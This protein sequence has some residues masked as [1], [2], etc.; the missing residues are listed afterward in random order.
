MGGTRHRRQRPSSI[1]SRR[2]LWIRPS[3]SSAVSQLLRRVH[4]THASA[5]STQTMKMVALA[6]SCPILLSSVTRMLQRN[7]QD[8]VLSTVDGHTGYAITTAEARA[9]VTASFL[10]YLETNAELQTH[11]NATCCRRANVP[12]THSIS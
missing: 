8:S 1:R 9:A 2:L 3:P 10:S 6:E 7:A 4:L 11:K 12:S 5:T